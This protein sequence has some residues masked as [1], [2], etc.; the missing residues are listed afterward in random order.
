VKLL[1]LNKI[2]LYI[3]KELIPFFVFANILFTFLL[4][5]EKLVNLTD[6]FIANNVSL[7]LILET[8]MFIV[9]S[10]LVLTIPL[11]ALL[12]TI[13]VFSKLSADNELIIIKSLGV[14]NF[15]IIKPVLLFSIIST[16][17]AIFL[18]VTIIDKS[19][20]LTINNINKIAENISINDIK[21]NEI[22]DKIPSILLYVNKKITDIDFTG[23]ILVN[24]T[25]K[26]I[27]TA[28]KATISP[29]KDKTIQMIFIDGKITKGDQFDK[30]VTILFKDMILT[31]P[32]NVNIAEVVTVASTMST[33][34]LIKNYSS[35][36][37]ARYELS[38]RFAVPISTIILSL[39]GFTLG[40]SVART[41]R[42]SGII[43]AILLAL[44]INF[45]QI[46]FEF[47]AYRETLPPVLAAWLPD[48][49]FSILLLISFKRVTR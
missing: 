3:L 43:I 47:A 24:K 44:L 6:L 28:K 15:N 35:D 1:G 31:I 20:K 17:L 46:N 40:V 9:P 38:K 32:I 23:V 11:S 7:I 37:K 25:D 39:F 42:T 10:I 22:Y 34:E 13:V 33:A 45:M 49:I 8:I 21:P 4:L 41:S 36:H 30:I 2:S 14:N 12:S 18:S 5:L 19:S 27:I 16:L 29:T 48:I 26:T